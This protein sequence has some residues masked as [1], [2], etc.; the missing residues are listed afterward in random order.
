M[1][2]TRDILKTYFETGDYPTEVQFAEL[3]D[4]YAHLNE[5]NFG[6]EVK[7]SGDYKSAYYHFYRAIDVQNS[8]AG[9]KIVQAATGSTPEAFGGFNHVLSRNVLFKTLEVKLLGGINV[10]THQPKIIVERYKQRK[11]YPSGY[12]RPAGFYKENTWDAAL[13]N[14]KSEYEVTSN[15][16]NLDLEPINYFKQGFNKS[17]NEFKPSGSFFRPGS[18]K[19]SR[20]AKPFVPVRLKLQILIDGVNYQ[21]RP[22]DLR[23]V[24]GSSGEFDTINYML[25]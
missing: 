12:K 21:S 13:W 3:I 20:H 9:H 10:E 6:L 8:G 1:K 24:L 16:M 22:V 11:K 19:F 4:S 15:Q 18:F 2:Q 23:I 7:P 14:R 5:F 17:Y 25:Y